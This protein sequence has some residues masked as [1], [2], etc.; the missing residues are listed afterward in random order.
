MG[1]Q[2]SAVGDAIQCDGY[3]LHVRAEHAETWA[4]KL[5]HTYVRHLSYERERGLKVAGNV[6][7]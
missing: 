2:I 7:N 6:G 4:A 5:T 1:W 3:Q